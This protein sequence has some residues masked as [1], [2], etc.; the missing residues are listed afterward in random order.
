MALVCGL[1]T[2]LADQWSKYVILRRHGKGHPGARLRFVPHR[3][4][5]YQSK[6]GRLTL[7][8]I[9]ILA[10]ASAFILARFGMFFRLE[11]SRAG[12]GLALGGAASNL[13]DILRYGYV[14]NYIDL[15]WWPAFNLADVGIVAGLSAALLFA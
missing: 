14:I 7:L 6:R 3:H 1:A 15:G 11:V 2:L 10:L 12:L 5:A 9:W 8:G 13:L 4:E